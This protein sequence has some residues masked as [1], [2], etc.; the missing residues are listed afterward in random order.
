MKSIGIT[1]TETAVMSFLL[2]ILSC[3]FVPFAGALADKV[4]QFKWIILGF[5]TLHVLFHLLLLGVPA[6]REIERHTRTEISSLGIEFV[7]QKDHS[8]VFYVPNH[9]LMGCATGKLTTNSGSLDMENELQI[10]DCFTDCSMRT[11]V[12]PSICFFSS[13]TTKGQYG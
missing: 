10:D 13:T 1:I 5:T 3:M 8:A 7:C 6:Y 12:S 2:P 9:A 4:G 11:G